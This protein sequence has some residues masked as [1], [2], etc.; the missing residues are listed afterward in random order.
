MRLHGT[1]ETWIE[2]FLKWIFKS[3]KQAIQTTHDINALFSKDLEKI[4][5]LGRVRFTCERAFEYLKKLPL[6]TVPLLAS[7]LSITAP[8]SRSA[9]NHMISLRIL[10]EKT[11]KKRDKI[12]VV[13][14]ELK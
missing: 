6:V 12:Y 11:E 5:G 8:T 10:E 3:A 4:S 7:S 13:G 1:W 14:P 9:L 2:F